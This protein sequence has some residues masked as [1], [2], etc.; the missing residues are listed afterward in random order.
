MCKGVKVLNL[1]GRVCR[2]MEKREI[3]RGSNHDGFSKIPNVSDV[4]KL[5]IKSLFQVLKSICNGIYNSIFF[6]YLC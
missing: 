5:K 4:C 1:R 3:T 2:S 6:I